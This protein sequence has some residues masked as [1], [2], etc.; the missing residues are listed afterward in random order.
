MENRKKF[1]FEKN[2]I[3]IIEKNIKNVGIIYIFGSYAEGIEREKSDVDIAFY[4]LENYSEYKIFLLAQKISA[5]IK[6][7]VDLVQLKKSS[8]VF[9][10]E[11]VSKGIVIFEKN[12]I[13][14]EKF[15]NTVLKKYMRLNEERKKILENYEV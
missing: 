6:K 7:E 13:E 9:Q 12:H 8:T 4:S 1:E 3:K 2:I 14:R 15:E 5:E 10:K 11:V